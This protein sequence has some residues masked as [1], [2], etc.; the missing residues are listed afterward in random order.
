MSQLSEAFDIHRRNKINLR[1]AQL[2]ASSLPP[3]FSIWAKTP[4]Q[5]LNVA[6]PAVTCYERLPKQARK[7]AE[8]L[9]A[10]AMLLIATVLLVKD[11]VDIE[12]EITRQIKA[13]V[14]AANRTGQQQ[15][16]ATQNNN[17]GSGINNGTTTNNY[18]NDAFS[19]FE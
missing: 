12:L 4:E 14:S 10:P 19:A 16:N 17:S 11:S 13:G 3:D 2:G 8:E 6:K 5:C 7:Q 9:A 15:G 1:L 18:A